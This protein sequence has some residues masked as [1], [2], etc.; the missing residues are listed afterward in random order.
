MNRR[1]ADINEL[2]DIMSSIR[3]GVFA[4]ICYMSAAKIGKT[5]SGK[6]IDIEQ[7]GNDLDNYRIDGDDETYN[8]LKQ[9]Q[10]GGSSR[11]NKFPYAGIVKMTTFEI[12]WQ[13][14]ENYNK[15]FHKYA[16]ERDK[17]LA[18]YGASINK[19]DEKH[20][21]MVSYGNG[22]S[23]GATPNTLGKMY[24][25]QN[26]ATIRNSNSEYFIVDENGDLKGGVSFNAIKQLVSTS[27]PDGVSA[28]KKVGASEEEIKKYVQDLKQLKFG[29][30]KLMYDSILF[31]VAKV[32]GENIVYINSN[33]SNRI[34]SGS[35]VVDINPQVFMD[36][37]NEKFADC[38]QNLSESVKHYDLFKTNIAESIKSILREVR[39]TT[40]DTNKTIKRLYNAVN[41]IT[42]KFFHDE[43]WSGIDSVIDVINNVIGGE[44]DLS[45]WCENGGY[46]KQIGEEG[47]Y[48]TWKLKIELRNG[49]VI[50]GELNANAAGTHEDPFG[51]YD[52]TCSFWR[53]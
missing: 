16:T 34:G 45:V 42:H 31:I 41:K 17:L 3:G 50:G 20:D 51:R 32:N 4:N 29:V 6:N 47:N 37:A 26:S 8:T 15:N 25:H 36:K 39:T 27:A 52:I 48:K 33:L 21:E 7:F 30:L 49:G 35:Y 40:Y 23:V 46:A 24:S 12:N 9:Y 14:E 10:Q 5:L 18:Q 53:E 43:D 2:I 19:R 11:K 1:I 13:S 22:V 44:G 38:V 28:L